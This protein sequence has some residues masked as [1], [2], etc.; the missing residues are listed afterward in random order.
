MRHL[1]AV[2]LALVAASLVA[3][4]S[5]STLRSSTSGSATGSRR[6]SVTS[7][8]TNHSTSARKRLVRK[9][10]LPRRTVKKVY[11]LRPP[12]TGQPL[13]NT[14]IPGSAASGTPSAVVPA[15]STYRSSSLSPIRGSSLAPAVVGATTG[16]MPFRST[17]GGVG[18]LGSAGVTGSYVGGGRTGYTAGSAAGSGPGAYAL[19]RDGRP[20]Y[21]PPGGTLARNG[22][23]VTGAGTPGGMGGNLGSFAPSVG[24]RPFGP[25]TGFSGSM[26]HLGGTFAAPSSHASGGHGRLR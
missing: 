5:D 3:A 12:V 24:G 19:G 4:Q 18:S 13:R 8:G 6:P 22:V 7:N 20:V 25:A 9:K 10:R 11:R 1:L 21:V 2:Y 15:P 26:G 16:S 23:P 17:G 14:A